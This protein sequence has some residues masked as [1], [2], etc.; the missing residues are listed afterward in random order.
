MQST[1]A[2][3]SLATAIVL[4]TIIFCVTHRYEHATVGGS[5]LFVI[6]RWTGSVT[7]CTNFMDFCELLSVNPFQK[8]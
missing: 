3:M 7:R 6:D 8:R 1:F 4:S 5:S 2:Q